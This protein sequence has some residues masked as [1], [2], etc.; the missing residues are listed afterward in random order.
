MADVEAKFARVTSVTANSGGGETRLLSPGTANTDY[1]GVLI[2]PRGGINVGDVF[3]IIAWGRTTNAGM[4]N[5]TARLKLYFN[6]NA[7]LNNP[8]ADSGATGPVLTLGISNTEWHFFAQIT[9]RTLGANVTAWC[10]SMFENLRPPNNDYNWM[11]GLG[12]MAI[13]TT[14]DTNKFE[15]TANVA[16]NGSFVLDQC[17]I[18]R[19]PFP[20]G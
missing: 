12:A 9:I 10:D 2:I 4:M 8:I 16:N 14:V 3:R 5:G 17:S 19:L 1:K 13:D 15:L 6:P 18:E 11:C 7:A 20:T